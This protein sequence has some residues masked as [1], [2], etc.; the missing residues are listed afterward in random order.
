MLLHIV[1]VGIITRT[2]GWILFIHQLLCWKLSVSRYWS[3]CAGLTA[4]RSFRS[5]ISQTQYQ[6][7]CSVRPFLSKTWDPERDGTVLTFMSWPAKLSLLLPT[8]RNVGNPNNTS[9]SCSAPQE[10]PAFLEMKSPNDDLYLWFTNLFCFASL[11][12]LKHWHLVF[13]VCL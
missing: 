10:V 3:V 9:T 8:E 13:N 12:S 7:K 6:N 5:V 4:S 11:V 1:N 2:R